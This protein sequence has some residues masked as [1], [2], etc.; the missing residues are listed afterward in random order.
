MACNKNEWHP[1]HWINYCISKIAKIPS[2][3]QDGGINVMSMGRNGSSLAWILKPTGKGHNKQ[4]YAK[5]LNW[6]HTFHSWIST[7]EIEDK[8]NNVYYML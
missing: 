2:T 8:L 1:V 4:L 5:W 3:E 6:S 7:E